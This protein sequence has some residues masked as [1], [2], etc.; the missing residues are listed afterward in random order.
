MSATAS[1][2]FGQ[3]ATASAQLDRVFESYAGPAFSIRFWD[4]SSWMSDDTNTTF[5]ICLRTES[6]WRALC[7]SPDDVS[8]GEKYIHGEIEVEGDLY[9]ALRAL[10]LLESAITKAIPAPIQ[11]FRHRSALLT[12]HMRRLANWGKVHSL[13]RD[14]AS[15]AHHYDKPPEF[16]R[17]FLGS[18][19]VYSCAYFQSWSKT[20]DEAQAEKMELICRK[21]DL[22]RDERFLDVGCGW[23]SLVL[24]A[25]TQ[26]GVISRGIS[27]SEKQVNHAARRISE[28]QPP[29]QCEVGLMDF[30]DLA[31]QKARFHKIASVGMCEHVG[32]KHIG[33]YFQHA[34]TMLFPRGLFLNHG[35]TRRAGANRPKPSFMDRYIFPDGELL[36]VSE[37]VNAA[38]NAGFEVR[39]VE[40]L[41]EHYE[42]TLHRWVS[43]LNE[44]ESEA[45]QLT[46]APTVRTWRLYMSGCA[47][48][49]RRGDIAIH[50]LLLSKNDHG[51]SSAAKVRE[52]WYRNGQKSGPR[53]VKEIGGQ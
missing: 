24:H 35:I 7:E 42:E 17:L 5:G 2:S 23:G 1:L 27:L 53:G 34:Y 51:L 37:M 46:D 8:L 30:R 3:A 52:R 10:P 43:A 14:A 39:D 15:I 18:S 40:D 12:N 21:L 48:A 29:P 28:Q 4:G 31:W 9:L 6:A 11:R 25:A 16:F 45:I 33:E 44:N 26:Y 19:M 41:R 13:Q 47:E 22:R 38:E 49:F 50:Q 36:T 20:L 32:L